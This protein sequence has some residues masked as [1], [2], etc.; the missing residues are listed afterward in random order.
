[1][2]PYLQVIEPIR[3]YV[4]VTSITVFVC[5]ISFFLPRI[6][7]INTNALRIFVII[8]VVYFFHICAFRVSNEFTRLALIESLAERQTF[9]IDESVFFPTKDIA[10]YDGHY[11]SKP[12]PG[13]ALLEVPVYLFFKWLFSTFFTEPYFN[14]I[15]WHIRFVL[16]ITT[17]LIS[18][19]TVILVY[20]TCKLFKMSELAA[21]L[22]AF[23][24]AFGTFAW[25]YSQTFFPHPLSSFLLLL[26]VYFIIKTLKDEEQKSPKFL[27][28][29]GS[30]MGY[31][32]LT[33]YT[34]FLVFVVI[35]MYYFVYTFRTNKASIRGKTK[36][37]MLFLIPV[38][39]WLIV[40]G[41]IN[42]TIY[43]SFFETGYMSPYDPD[44]GASE[45]FTTPLHV[46][47][48]GLLFSE[49]RGLFYY[50]P[51]LLI[52]CYGF[53]RF[54]KQYPY[55][56][57]LFGSA[58]LSI[59]LLFSTWWR[60]W[61]GACYGPRFIVPVIS[62]L[63]IPLGFVVDERRKNR[64]F[65]II[66]SILLLYSM[67]AMSIGVIVD[68]FV[69]SGRHVPNPLLYGLRLLRRIILQRG[70]LF[71]SWSLRELGVPLSLTL[72][73]TLLV[74]ANLL[75]SIAHYGSL[76]KAWASFLKI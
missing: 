59:L 38:C 21:I 54:V 64:L 66:F 13:L 14:L 47:L 41:T 52:G 9:I 73:S 65:W 15:I 29:S 48:Y 67:A 62:F 10:F 7:R 19:F 75:I 39:V 34:N 57:L 35:I 45:G 61:G 18:T 25:V 33:E 23:V 22:T 60:P 49:Y 28:I 1:M 2:I 6:R 4:V 51:I 70:G 27:L 24:Y 3:T 50:A 72:M 63:T 69:N 20:S 26:G 31:S 46:G 42:Y 12:A 11:Y 44:F 56:A 58:F 30:A 32:I 55:E 5:L 76:R 16:L 43:D 36:E 68:V 40:L 71:E 37:F 8:F 17:V 53:K 74:G